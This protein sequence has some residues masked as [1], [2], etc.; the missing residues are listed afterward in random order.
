MARSNLNA[1][2]FW[3][4]TARERARKIYQIYALGT[5]VQIKPA[6]SAS[7]EIRCTN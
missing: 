5:S 7:K 6:P 2:Y 3:A 4:C 1:Q